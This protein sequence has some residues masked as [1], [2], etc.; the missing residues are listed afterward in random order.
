MTKHSLRKDISKL[1][2]HLLPHSVACPHK[3]NGEGKFGMLVLPCQMV[4]FFLVPL[5]AG[6]CAHTV[7]DN[8]RQE[9]KLPIMRRAALCAEAGD[10]EGAITL[11]KKALEE[12][13]KLARAHLDLA[14]LLHDQ[15]RDYLAAI[16]HYRRYLELRPTTEKKELINDRIRLASQSFAATILPAD[17]FMAEKVAALEKENELLKGRVSALMQELDRIRASS[18][19]AALLKQNESLN[20]KILQL[21]RELA[22]CRGRTAAVNPEP[23]HGPRTYRV[24]PGDTLSSIASRFYGDSTQWRRIYEA[25]Q[26]ILGAPERVRVGQ[27]LVIP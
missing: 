8:D 11:Y 16:Y 2:R 14:V 13:P 9:R 4:L 7:A 19:E 10:I 24:Q 15:S 1:S 27:E 26:N 25:N 17:R 21:E 20:A 23:S 18:R 3:K 22:A 6:G 12:N 5:L